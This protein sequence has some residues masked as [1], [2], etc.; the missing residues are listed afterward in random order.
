VVPPELDVSS[1]AAPLLLSD[2]S[3][4][5]GIDVEDVDAASSPLSASLL[6]SPGPLDGGA[7]PQSVIAEQ[8][9][10]IVRMSILASL[11]QSG[12]VAMPNTT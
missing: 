1:S 8:S 6:S 3:V 4:A 2:V 12:F 10:V 9:I 7:Q 11:D 5:S